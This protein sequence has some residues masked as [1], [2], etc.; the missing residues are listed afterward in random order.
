MDTEPLGD[1]QMEKQTV[2]E[3]NKSMFN[4]HVM[5]DVN[6]VVPL[7][8]DGEVKEHIHAHK[9]VLAISSPVF[10]A[11]FYGNLAEKSSEIHLPDADSSSFLAFLKYL[12]CDEC[13]LTVESAIDVLYLAKKYMLPYLE[14][15]CSNFLQESIT[16]AN[17]FTLLGQS[18]KI[19]EDD[20]QKKC[21]Y[22][23]ESHCQEALTSTAFLNISQDILIS[24][25]EFEGL[26]VKEINLFQAL[27]KWSTHQLK[28]RDLEPT[29]ENRRDVLGNAVY[30]IRYLTMSQKEF[31][32]VVSK[33]DLLT[34]DEVIA[35]FQMLNGVSSSID[36]FQV[37]LNKR[38]QGKPRQLKPT[39][40][41]SRFAKDQI[42]T[43]KTL[44]GWQYTS[45]TPDILSFSVDK[46]IYFHGVRLFGTIGHSISYHVDMTFS[47]TRANDRYYS[48]RKNTLV[49]GFDVLLPSP[50]VVKKGL[51]YEISATIKG[52]GSYYGE[53][54]MS[55]VKC[56]GVSFNFR[57]CCDP[58]TPN[59]KTLSER[60]QFYEILFS[61]CCYP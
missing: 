39:H 61:L 52:A 4:Q 1:W 26:N 57:D 27:V 2:L 13:K 24:M 20:L 44:C 11:M 48:E 42:R 34:K 45:G 51:W 28:E 33:C 23:I 47:N 7:R 32:E 60:G 5:S 43:S 40:R 3:R 6:F 41:C 56:A 9:Y 16:A 38:I 30:Y 58:D 29:T 15:L 35:I 19:S 8:K 31:A 12:Y 37:N 22:F 46:D 54:G 18:L 21:W 55:S 53:R 49:P 36:T 14:K 10:Y 25:L 59:N 50:V 17:A